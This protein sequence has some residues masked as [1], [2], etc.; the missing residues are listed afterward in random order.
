MSHPHQGRIRFHIKLASDKPATMAL[1]VRSFSGRDGLSDLFQFE[2]E[3]SSRERV[4]PGQAIGK[5]ATLTIGEP[6]R[7]A[8]EPRSD[9]ERSAQHNAARVVHGVIGRFELVARESDVVQHDAPLYL[10]RVHLLPRVWL[11]LSHGRNCR[12]FQ[13]QTVRQIV[14]TLLTEAKLKEDQDFEFRIPSNDEDTDPREYCVQYNESDWTFIC[15]LLEEQGIYFYFVHGDG[16]VRDRLILASPGTT[17]PVLQALAEDQQTRS[18]ALPYHRTT[19]NDAI[20]KEHVASLSLHQVIGADAYTVRDQALDLPMMQNNYREPD[21]KAQQPREVYEYIGHPKTSAPSALPAFRLQALQT[22]QIV[23]EG[24]SNCPAL[25]SGVTFSVKGHG[26]IDLPDSLMALRVQHSGTQSQGDE[27]VFY[28]G[29]TFACIPADLPFRP[30]RRV[31]R[32]VIPGVQSALVVGLPDVEIYTDPLGRVKVQFPWDRLGKL[33]EKSSCWVPVAQT[34]AGAQWG[35]LFTPRIKQQVVVQFLDGD[36]DQP[37]IVG[38][39][40]NRHNPPPCDLPKEKTRSTIKTDSSPHKDQARY[41]ELR[42][43]D[44][45]GAEEVYLRAQLNRRD[46]VLNDYGLEVGHQYTQ[47]VGPE[48]EQGLVSYNQTVQGSKHSAVTEDHIETVGK[49]VEL[50]AKGPSRE[51][52]EEAKVEELGSLTQT[53]KASSST[54]VQEGDATVKVVKGKY[55]VFSDGMLTLVSDDMVELKAGSKDVGT[56]TVTSGEIKIVVGDSEITMDRKKTI[57]NVGGGTELT[58]DAQMGVL[59]LGTNRVVLNQSGITIMGGM[60]TIKGDSMVQIN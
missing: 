15:R 1:Q 56:V 10:Y 52:V 39:I 16:K 13:H 48:K 6:S 54:K 8:A 7:R 17:H 32:P 41:N 49:R 12:I 31:P 18:H 60:V 30:A 25:M 24:T 43:E 33:N 20:T 38:Q 37:L 28:Y 45:R 19:G 3:L 34:W 4:K 42:F 55:S 21:A 23:I 9:A 36:P 2:I 14:T 47:L 5:D 27:D 50:Y 59:K 40:Y 29:N 57:L 58:M 53:I 35:T 22:P 44:K 51:V 46:Q 11:L 26:D